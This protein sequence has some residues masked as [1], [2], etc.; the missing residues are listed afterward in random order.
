MNK[1]EDNRRT[2]RSSRGPLDSV[3]DAQNCQSRTPNNLQNHMPRKVNKLRASSGCV[4]NR[5]RKLSNDAHEPS[6]F[7]EPKTED[8]SLTELAN[9]DETFNYNY[10][11]SAD[12]AK[13][14]QDQ[15]PDACRLQSSGIKDFPTGYE[16][17]NQI[18]QRV[19]EET[20]DAVVREEEGDMDEDTRRIREAEAALRSLSGDFEPD[21]GMDIFAGVCGG[22]TTERPFFE[23]L[24]EKKN[25]VTAPKTAEVVTN[26]WKD[27]VTLS[28]SSSS[29]C[30]SERSPLRSPI[31]SPVVSIH[32]IKEERREEQELVTSPM[33]QQP[34]DEEY[35]P[36]GALRAPQ[37]HPQHQQ[38]PQPQTPI[39]SPDTSFSVPA[40]VD[41][42]PMSC[43]SQY[44]SAD[45]VFDEFTPLPPA[46][47]P[48][49]DSR[50]VDNVGSSVNEGEPYDV[51]SLL[52]IEECA[53]IQSLVESDGFTM[54]TDAYSREQQFSRT[55]PMHDIKPNIHD[56]RHLTHQQQQPPPPQSYCRMDDG[57]GGGEYFQP[58]G[59]PPT[60]PASRRY[61]LLDSKLQEPVK[62]PLSFDD[63]LLPLPEDDHPLVIDEGRQQQQHR[64]GGL[65][66]EEDS[67]SLQSCSQQS[68]STPHYNNSC[69]EMMP[70]PHSDMGDGRR[71]LECQQSSPQDPSLRDGKCPTPGCN[72]SGHVTGLYSH[73]RS[74]SGCPRKDRITPEI[75]ALH[76]TIL[77]CPTNGCNGRGHV[78]S[79][80]ISHRSLSGCPIAAMEK[81]VQKEQRATPKPSPPVGQIP[82]GPSSPDC[83]MRTLCYVKH[84]DMPDYRYPMYGQPVRSPMEKYGRP[85]TPDYNSYDSQRFYGR[86]PM[87]PKIK[88]ESPDGQNLLNKSNMPLAPVCGGGQRNSVVVSSKQIYSPPP[89]PT[90]DSE[91]TEPVDFSTGHDE[92]V[93]GPHMLPNATP[94]PSPR[95]PAT[96]RSPL[97]ASPHCPPQHVPP[98]PQSPLG[99]PPPADRI[100]HHHLMPS[101]PEYV[102]EKCMPQKIKSR[103]REGRELIHCPT[104]G[105]DGMG[106]ISGNYATHR[107]LSGCPHADRSQI[108]AQ[109]QELKPNLCY[110]EKPSGQWYRYPSSQHDKSMSPILRC[111]TPGC[112]G[113][114]H[115]TGN[116]SSHRS[117]SGCPRANK[118][119]KMVNRDEKNDP[120]PLRCPIPGCDG[121]GHVTGKFQ[122]HRSCPTP[123]CD[124]SGHA[125][126]TFLTHRSLSGCPRAAQAVRKAKAAADEDAL[127]VKHQPATGVE[128]LSNIRALEEEIME[129]QEYNAR[130]ESEMFQLRTDI[131]QMEPIPR[132]TDRESPHSTAQKT[133]QLSEYY[134]SLR[135]NFINLLDH[136]RLPSF[137]EKP[138]PDN[139]DTYLNRLQSL[140][141]DNSKE[142]DSRNVFSSVKQAMQDFSAPMQQANGWVRS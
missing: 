128:D 114:G 1:E 87:V 39:S 126:G 125:N 110:N 26:S 27:V 37:Q 4:S 76:E 127:P 141:A 44:S 131:T 32:S 15:T 8:G 109:H 138:T 29:C 137:D 118:P 96:G 7:K 10:R 11:I 19:V 102:P 81:M 86:P 62:R 63:H 13:Q 136:V 120:E 112:D 72:G 36:Q 31:L 55:E 12:S 117:L 68:G 113:S 58:Y 24:F 46:V 66:D 3:Q 97:D 59:C 56:M 57:Y 88:S 129:L 50:S 53:N 135:N 78:N 103:G 142:E 47:Q 139:F 92:R 28:A 95:S 54:Q 67:N 38:Q 14:P 9:S 18:V 122:S 93:P 85:Q 91:Q 61:L 21:T 73:H 75:L 134:E 115:V 107:S 42:K 121:S 60:S 6:S 132:P 106:H 25:E 34:R 83:V 77:K 5:K 35:S 116:Y 98:Y 130:V 52:K 65:E 79:N 41:A 51:A 89:P 84:T 119:K 104:P 74:L 108:Q 23:N 48:Q 90:N 123:G 100:Q 22:V 33:Y 133:S 111:P 49:E 16:E 71:M 2:T 20:M 124:G 45:E 80:R 69:C 40:S 43:T 17:E 30:S 94:S 99:P 140:C 101:P 70:S 82:S 105:C 64:Y